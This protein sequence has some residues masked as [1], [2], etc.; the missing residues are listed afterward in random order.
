M[1][2]DFEINTM[3]FDE[4]DILENNLRKQYPDVLEI[5]LI[6]HTTNKNILW[7]TN[8]Y[9][10]LGEGY[11]YESQIL[12]KLITGLH[13]R[14]IMPRISKEKAI[15]QTRIRDMAEVFTPSWICN[16]QN[17]LIDNAWFE[18]NNVFNTELIESDGSHTWKAN[19]KIIQFPKGKKWQDYV[20]DTRL[21][22]TCGEAP[23]ITSRYCNE[24][25]SSI[26]VENRIGLLDRKLR[27]VN[28]NVETKK[29][30]LEAAKNAFENIYAYEWQGDSLLLAREAMLYTFIE[31]HTQKFGKKPSPTSVKKIAHI[32]SW[33]IW[34]MDGLKG[35]V[36]NSC[37][38]QT[39]ETQN[40]FGDIQNIVAPCEGCSKNNITKHNG[41]YC[42]IMDWNKK[43]EIKYID[44]LK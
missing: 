29:E 18:S 15:Q 33:N 2:N 22:I 24:T 8:N 28:E 5:L 14:V 21:E 40:L 30:W 6:D 36:P 32:I 11:E 20:R 35:V 17:N 7:A 42:V 31:N 27:I 44:L 19:P 9:L 12:P 39:N 26:P 16:A 3:M 38:K 13:G 23:Y 25:G 4:A 1:L 41:I 37:S 43:K 10:K 34:Q